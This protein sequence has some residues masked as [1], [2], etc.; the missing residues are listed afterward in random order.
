MK[1]LLEI[2]NVD[3]IEIGREMW[4]L[5]AWKTRDELDTIF[6]HAD[7]VFHFGAFVPRA[8]EKSIE[9]DEEVL[10]NVFDVNVRSCVAIAE[11]ALYRNLP[12]IYLSG[13]TVYRDPH[14]L[15]IVEEADKAVDSFGGWYGFSKYL[16]EQ[17]FAHFVSK[18]LKAIILRPSSIY[19]TGMPNDRLV[20]RFI[21]MAL[22]GENIVITEPIAN[23][24][25]F[26]HA[27][28]VANAAFQAFNKESWGTFNIAANRNETIFEVATQCVAQIGQG[29]VEIIENTENLA[30]F[31][32]FDLNYDKARQSFDYKASVDIVNGIAAMID[33][34]TII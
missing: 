11:W 20:A 31:T 29:A 33:E 34:K 13:A 23:S 3:L 8:P 26:I 25:N 18:G 28:D 6:L 24:V 15:N 19:G 21:Q 17:I 32:R 14:A 5:A 10:K 27:S 30:P 22:R 9:T 1:N 12:V 7:A 2:N 16:A 4:D